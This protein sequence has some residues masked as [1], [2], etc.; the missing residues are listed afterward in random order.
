M[1]GLNFCRNFFA[2]ILVFKLEQIFPK[3]RAY[4]IILLNILICFKNW[5]PP[6]EY[7]NFIG[8]HNLFYFLFF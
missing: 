4:F 3:I 5:F 8:M 6:Q 1:G 7:L 2:I